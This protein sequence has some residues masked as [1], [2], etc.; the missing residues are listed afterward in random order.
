[1]LV[2]DSSLPKLIYPYIVGPNT[3]A[4]FIDSITRANTTYVVCL[5]LEKLTY[6]SLYIH[7]KTISE[8]YFYQKK[9]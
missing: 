2:K 9:N 6:K 8:R 7:N 1:M 5:D 3:C 4:R